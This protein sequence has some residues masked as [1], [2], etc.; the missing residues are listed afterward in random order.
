MINQFSLAIDCDSRSTHA[1]IQ[2]LAAY[3]Q[4]MPLLPYSCVVTQP[5]RCGLTLLEILVALFIFMIITLILSRALHLIVNI[6]SETENKAHALSVLQR[7]LLI[8]AHD[9]QTIIDRPT[10]DAA[11]K[12]QVSLT[13][14]PQSMTFTHATI[15][16]NLDHGSALRR[17]HY[18]WQHGA[19][20]RE[21]WQQLDLP[22]HAI[23][24]QQLLLNHVTTIHFQYLN[25]A[26][27]FEDRWPINSPDNTGALPLAIRVSLNITPW[28]QLEQVYILAH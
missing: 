26:G 9:T 17:I 28:G 21:T 27:Q 10:L 3:T 23:S 14:T 13:G 2:E 12:E 20:W 5:K 19:L 16:S 6:Q 7:A 22:P 25:R 18:F 15:I 11:G 8:M 24:Q 1:P 4:A